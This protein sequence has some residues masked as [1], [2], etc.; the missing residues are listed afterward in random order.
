MADSLLAQALVRFT[1]PQAEEPIFRAPFTIQM[2]GQVWGLAVTGPTLVAVKGKASYPLVDS[3]PYETFLQTV[4][5][6]ADEVQLQ[7]LKD[8]CGPPGDQ[9]NEAIFYGR[10]F[11]R[12]RLANLLDPIPFPKVQIGVFD[13]AGIPVLMV[14]WPGKFRVLLAGMASE[15]AEGM[16]VWDPRSSEAQVFDLAMDLE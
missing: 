12:T 3:A 4:P 2:G 13:N 6:K 9:E 8:W 5:V 7:D 15:P 16:P 10:V 1:A 14:Y 11:N